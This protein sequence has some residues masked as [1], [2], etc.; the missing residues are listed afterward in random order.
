MGIA[1]EHEIHKR[2]LGRN[3]GLGIV[4]GGFVVLVF[5][6]TM[7]KLKTGEMIKGYDYEPPATQQVNQ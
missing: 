3:L 2:R 4:L 7:A 1:H 6:L 5:A